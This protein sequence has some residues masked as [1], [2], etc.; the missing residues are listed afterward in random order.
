MLA[1]SLQDLAITIVVDADVKTVR[2]VVSNPNCMW[3]N[4]CGGNI[5]DKIFTHKIQSHERALCKS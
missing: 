2:F 3:Y 5:Y 1:D 4:V